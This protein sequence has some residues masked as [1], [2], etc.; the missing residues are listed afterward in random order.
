MFFAHLL[1][2]DFSFFFSP[3]SRFRIR[4]LPPGRSNGRHALRLPYVH[5]ERCLPLKEIKDPDL[6]LFYDWL[7]GPGS[8]H[9]TPVRRQSRPVEPRHHRFPM[10]HWTGPVHGSNAASP[11]DVLRTEPQSQPK[12]KTNSASFIFLLRCRIAHETKFDDCLELTTH[13]ESDE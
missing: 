3:R 8:D 6:L 9:V 7:P 1:R 12:V 2:P 4:S 10:P 5:G 11:Q 13:C